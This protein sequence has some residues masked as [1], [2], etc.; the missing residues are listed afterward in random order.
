MGWDYL[1]IPILKWARDYLFMLGLKLIGI[2]CQLRLINFS[3]LTD[4][5]NILCIKS[6]L[7]SIDFDMF[8]LYS[9]FPSPYF[10]VFLKSTIRCQTRLSTQ[11]KQLTGLML[12]R[13][14]T[15]LWKKLDVAR[16]PV[17]SNAFVVQKWVCNMKRS[18]I[19]TCKL[20]FVL[21]WLW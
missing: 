16:C 19:F 12:T 5:M 4:F 9:N 1:S 17:Y 7:I 15:L 3:L 11:S 13:K 8:F 10:G 18:W 14:L 6:T 2:F 21:L 20:W